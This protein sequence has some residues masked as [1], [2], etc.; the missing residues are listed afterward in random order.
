MRIIKD[1]S[2]WDRFNATYNN[3]GNRL[4]DTPTFPVLV[5]DPEYRYDAQGPDW[6]DFTTIQVEILQIGGVERIVVCESEI[7]Q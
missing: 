7:L 1:V 3:Q 5:T 2:D 4:R 6:W